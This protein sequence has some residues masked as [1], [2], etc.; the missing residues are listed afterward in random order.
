MNLSGGHL[1]GLHVIKDYI[2]DNIM[3][4]YITS[5]KAMQLYVFCGYGPSKLKLYVSKK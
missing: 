3:S 2:K 1:T 5:I 4:Q